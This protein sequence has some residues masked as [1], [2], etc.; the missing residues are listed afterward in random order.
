MSR[1]ADRRDILVCREH[2]A[3]IEEIL[4]HFPL[5]VADRAGDLHRRL[6]QLKTLLLRHLRFED[7]HLYPRLQQSSDP[8]V[9]ETAIRYQA[10]MG[11]L[12]PQCVAFF[13]RWSD[14]ETMRR[15]FA[16]FKA[17]WAAVRGALEKRILAEDNEL[18][19]LAERP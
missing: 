7:D 4:A 8:Q 12:A 2:H 10:E 11:G 5:L 16:E 15:R 19:Q 18:Y 3:R 17:E 6:T 1:L 14:D 13:D 9:V